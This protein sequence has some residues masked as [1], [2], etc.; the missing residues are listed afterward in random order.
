MCTKYAHVLWRRRCRAII[1]LIVRPVS[2]KH[3]SETIDRTPIVP[4]RYSNVSGTHLH[5]DPPIIFARE[6]AQNVSLYYVLLARFSTRYFLTLH[7]VA[8]QSFVFCLNFNI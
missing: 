5:A 4:I 7:Q 6:I 2:S 3:L 1:I 8:L